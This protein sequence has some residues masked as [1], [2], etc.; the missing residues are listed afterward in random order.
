MEMRAARRGMMLL[1]AMLALGFRV[2]PQA[3]LTTATT[4]P[5]HFIAVH[6]HRSAVFGYAGRGLEIWGYPFQILDRYTVQVQPQGSPEVMSGANLLTR[7]DVS[8]NQIVRVWT[9]PGFQVRETEFVPVDEP[10]AILRYDV[11]G[12]TAV[13]LVIRCRPVMDLMW[14]ASAG[15]QDVRWDDAAHGYILSESTNHYEAVV[16][17]P[18][19]EQHEPIVNSTH[20][21][22]LTQV[23]TLHPERQP[24]GSAQAK[25][26]VAL[27]PPGSDPEITL[28]RLIKNEGQ[29]RQQSMDHLRAWKAD[30]LSITTPDP[31]VNRALDWADTDLNQSWA[32]DDKIG[33]AAVAGYGPSRPGRRPQYDW[34]F[35]GDGMIDA[36]AMLASG[37]VKWAQQELEFVLRYQN[38]ANGMMWHEI[39]QSA[40]FL[41]WGKYPYLY[42]HIDLSFQFISTLS[43]Y[44][45][46]TGDL[47]FINTHWSSISAAFH[48]CQSLLDATTGLPMIPANK[49][50]A[51][52]Q[53]RMREDAGLSAAW[54][55]AASAYAQLA[56]A[57]GHAQDAE[58]AE[59]MSQ[60]ARTAY[61]G[62]YWSDADQFWVS[63]YTASGRAINVRR[64]G[65]TAALT[66]HLLPLA[67]ES[68][69]LD[70]LAG[71]TFESDWGTRSLASDSPQ[72]D[73]GSYS[74]GSVSAL[75]TAGTAEAFWSEHRP[76]SAWQMWSGLIPWLRLNSLGHMEEVLAG[77][78]FAPEVES[79]PEQTWSSAGFLSAALHGLFGVDVDAPAHHLTLAPHHFPGG[80]TMSIANLHAE[81]A[82]VSMDVESRGEE[83]DVTLR[84]EGEPIQ[85]SLVP[86]IPLGASRVHAD[87]DGKSMP[88]AVHSWD[89]E[90]QAQVD[91]ALPHGVLHCRFEYAGGVWIEIPRADPNPGA[92]SMLPHIND[93][94]LHSTELAIKADALTG[95]ESS[96]I[97]DTPWAIA[98]VDGGSANNISD[99]RTKIVFAPAAAPGESS[100]YV[101]TT[102]RIRFNTVR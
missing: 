2:W 75:H 19:I 57:T 41:D 30:S 92:N 12:T 87:I 8:P 24:D 23:F 37:H 93:I 79:V 17:S 40:G 21:E 51:N 44:Y 78:V 36:E 65:P 58:G 32:C 53:D 54:I 6:G 15:G 35:A 84:N 50:G 39:S 67:D 47:A 66:E 33:C 48:F 71:A 73:P 91:L 89:E 83:I 90:Q 76:I 85:L 81:G 100:H 3:A 1:L 97:L 59:A 94:T 25:L 46:T 102:I 101:S 10:A 60:R 61:A 31:E 88:V 13:N 68:N 95:I 80:G 96:L 56:R 55:G 5:Y 4:E 49:M 43:A 29:L 34:F 18:Q 52:E 9:G 82:V 72:Y 69:M 14:P 98:A 26:Y 7:V 28:Q 77:D 27:V 20:R 99:S 42:P 22:D 74:M 16:A 38:P 62:R 45:K 64:S 70:D 86:E 11:T 63:G